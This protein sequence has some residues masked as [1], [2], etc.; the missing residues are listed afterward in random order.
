MSAAPQ[1]DSSTT[2]AVV[3]DAN[4]ANKAEEKKPAAAMEGEDEW[5]EFPTQGTSLRF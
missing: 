4:N 2:K 5:E 1:G 3:D